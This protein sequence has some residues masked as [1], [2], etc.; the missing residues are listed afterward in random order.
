MSHGWSLLVRSVDKINLAC[1]YNESDSQEI[2]LSRDILCLSEF[3]FDDQ[4]PF[5]ILKDRCEMCVC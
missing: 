5:L 1:R 4:I 3:V 2:H